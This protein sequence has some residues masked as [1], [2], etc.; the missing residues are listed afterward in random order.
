MSYK[1]YHIKNNSTR[2]NNNNN[3]N[4]IAIGLQVAIIIVNFHSTSMLPATHIISVL[5]FV[6]F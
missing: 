1:M 2:N 5:L 3:N 6:D 4:R